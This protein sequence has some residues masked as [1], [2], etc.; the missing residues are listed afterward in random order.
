M[1]QLWSMIYDPW[2]MIHDLWSM[3]YDPWS[4]IRAG[5]ERNDQ[6]PTFSS[7]LNSLFTQLLLIFRS[8]LSLLIQR[9]KNNRWIVFIWIRSCE[10][11]FTSN[12]QPRCASVLLHM[13][14][15]SPPS[16]G[17]IKL[18]FPSIRRWYFR[19]LYIFA[20]VGNSIIFPPSHHIL[21][22]G[23]NVKR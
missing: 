14:L 1:I 2:S 11:D 8:S 22:G 23:G 17:K 9:K 13:T 21:V 4:I 3:I 12:H 16:W 6:F 18:Y 19:L 20:Q 10:V 15:P 5:D 7:D